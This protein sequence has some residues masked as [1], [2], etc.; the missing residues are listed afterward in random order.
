MTEALDLSDVACVTYTTSKYR[1]LWPCHFGQMTKHAGGLKSYA[2]S[3]RGSRE[4][5]DFGQHELIEHDDEAPYW[6]TYVEA[7][8]RIPEQYV[9]YL[10]EDFF[11]HED[12][13]LARIKKYRDFLCDTDY[14]Y[15]RLLRCGY[16]TPLDKHVKDNIFEVD[17]ATNDAYCQQSTLWKKSRMRE[18]YCHVASQKWLEGDHWNVGCR[19]IG[20]KGTFVWHGEKQIGKFHYDSIVWPAVSTAVN[21]GQWNMSEMPEVM[22]R[23]V[24]E[25][26]I[27]TSIRGVRK[28]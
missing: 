18:L 17:M 22:N 27:D 23:L 24:K 26:N 25:Y 28:R 3:D 21:R 7:L 14:D 1:D 20:L 12:V 11:L 10:Q 6:R 9:V 5:F 15:V 8:D 13:E 19:Q 2:L 4:L 16:S